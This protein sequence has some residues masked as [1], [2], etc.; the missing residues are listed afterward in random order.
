MHNSSWLLLSTDFTDL[1]LVQDFSFPTSKGNSTLEPVD[2][3]P[4]IWMPF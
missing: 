4:K 1:T 3:G 2:V